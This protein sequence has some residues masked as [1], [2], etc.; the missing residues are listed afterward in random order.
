MII[1]M[2][3]TLM[4]MCKRVRESETSRLN[5]AAPRFNPRDDKPRAGQNTG[6]DMDQSDNAQN[7]ND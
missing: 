2:G 7:L 6:N 3:E 1:N 4:D 5:R